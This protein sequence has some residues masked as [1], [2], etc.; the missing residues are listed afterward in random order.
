MQPKHHPLCSGAFI[1]LFRNTSR[2]RGF[3]LIEL[4]VVVAIISL[5][6]SV[7]MPA[8][9]AARAQA[10]TVLC[11]NSQ[12]A[13]AMAFHSYAEENNGWAPHCV[14]ATWTRTWLNV[15]TETGFVLT[16]THTES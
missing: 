6:V 14:N 4:L 12:K 15:M 1:R 10:R 2:V 8:L 13:L 16:N 7:L 11:M 3:T 5:L 9:S